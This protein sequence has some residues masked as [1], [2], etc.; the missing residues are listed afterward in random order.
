M[1]ERKT[2][3]IGYVAGKWPL[4]PDKSTLVFIHGAGG[5][6]YLWRSQIDLLTDKANTLALDLPGH[7]RSD[8]PGKDKI[9]DYTQAVNASVN[10]LNIPK[11]I[12]C[13]HSLGGAIAQQLLMDYPQ[14]CPAGILIGTGA[15]M[16]VAPAIFEAI[17][18][19]YT[20]FVEMITKFARSKKTEPKLAQPFKDD[21]A[22]CKPEVVT[23][24]FRACDRFDSESKL[25]LIEVPVLIITSEDDKLTPVKY[26]EFLE[27]NIQK[28]QRVH[29]MDA[30][31]I[32]SM[33]RPDKVNKAI[34]AFLEKEGL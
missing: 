3:G 20:E 33:E 32:V 17:E 14:R 11:P 26:G 25:S 31:H 19:N 9:E 18:K 5:S 6:G 8:G 4:D 34:Q 21:F 23:G 15:R 13:G 22:K 2:G 24:D 7:N 30:G 12:P 1:E 16:K 27:K 10:E 28:A 29:I